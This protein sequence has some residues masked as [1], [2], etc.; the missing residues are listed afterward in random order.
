MKTRTFKQKVESTQREIVELQKQGFGLLGT[1][2]ATVKSAGE[3]TDTTDKIVEGFFRDGT[4]GGGAV[5]LNVFD[6]KQVQVVPT[7]EGVGTP[8]KGYIKWGVDDRLPLNIY[9]RANALPY[10][11]TGLKYLTDLMY[12]LGPRLMYKYVRYAGQTVTEELIPFEN[13]GALL[14]RLIMEARSRIAQETEGNEILPDD[15]YLRAIGAVGEK[16][17]AAVSESVTVPKSAAVPEAAT[18]PEAFP[19]VSPSEYR[20]KKEETVTAPD[21]D[22]N[23]L[24]TPED[25]LHR[26]IEEYKRWEAT[27]REY[28]QFMQDNDIDGVYQQCCMDDTHLDISFPVLGLNQ[29]RAGQW[30][31]KVVKVDV[32]PA[33]CSRLEQMDERLNI[34]NVYYSERLRDENTTEIQAREMVAYPALMAKNFIPKLRST[35]EYHRRTAVTKRPTWFCCPVIYPSGSRPYYPQ[36]AWW[37]IFSSLVYNYASTLITDKAIARKNSTMWGKLI[38]INLNYLKELAD[39]QGLTKPEEIDKLKNEIIDNIDSF[40]RDRTNNGKTC[41]LENYIGPDGKTVIDSIKLVD[42]PAPNKTT[43]TAEELKAVADIVFFALGINPALVGVTIGSGSNGGTFQ[44]ELHLLKQQQ[45]SPRQRKQ[46]Q[47]WNRIL[48]FNGWDEHA[49]WVIKM[50]ILTTLDRSATGLVETESK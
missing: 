9:R 2:H 38:F 11:A 4:L 45:M 7:P 50:P 13:A 22:F 20:T 19:S 46:L 25:E 31:A 16:R 47:F 26:L 28:K 21:T 23:A 15:G 12:G 35:V 3:K 30:N 14:R 39:Q 6:T 29:G 17:T 36:P 32:W 42:V 1:T 49:E 33:I 41:T 43:A 48:Q 44:R 5:G 10:T 24:G 37:S 27:N 34:N 8:N 40:L 18:V